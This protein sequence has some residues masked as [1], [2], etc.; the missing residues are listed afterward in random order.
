MNIIE[1]AKE[2]IVSLKKSIVTLSYFNLTTEIESQI[3][4]H[5]NTLELNKAIIAELTKKSE[6]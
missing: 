4:F 5:A 3:K 2:R 1:M 6:S